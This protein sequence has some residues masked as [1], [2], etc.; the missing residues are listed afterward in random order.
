RGEGHHIGRAALLLVASS[1][2]SKAPGTELAAGCAAAGAASSPLS[3]VFASGWL[4]AAVCPVTAGAASGWPPTVPAF[5]AAFFPV[6]PGEDDRPSR[7][8]RGGVSGSSPGPAAGN[9]A[10]SC[11]CAG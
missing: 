8:R 1:G 7:H 2:G 4:C 6:A 11:V 3:S 5:A 9:P 10:G